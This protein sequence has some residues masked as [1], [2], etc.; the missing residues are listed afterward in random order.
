MWAAIWGRPDR[1]KLETPLR[2]GHSP[3]L[4]PPRV[5]RAR[6]GIETGIVGVVREHF[7]AA[8]QLPGGI[9][10]GAMKNERSA[11]LRGLSDPLGAGHLRGLQL[12]RAGPHARLLVLR[13]NGRERDEYSDERRERRSHDVKTTAARVC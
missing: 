11:R 1:A 3:S 8:E 2:V 13:G 9:G 10:D 6:R 5:G 7:D 4:E 12:L